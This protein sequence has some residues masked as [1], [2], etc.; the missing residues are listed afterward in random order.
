M[1]YVF[2]PSVIRDLKKLQKLIQAR[3]I[4]KL[5]FFIDSE[6]PLSFAE[7]LNDVALGEFRFRI[8]DYR[9]IF[10]V[11]QQ[12]IIILAIGHRKNIYK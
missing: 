2:K 9:V 5:D 1:D 12:D 11:E 4:K 7:R 6:D 3:V 8:G 10:N